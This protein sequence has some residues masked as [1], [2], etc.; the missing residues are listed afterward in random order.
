[1]KKLKILTKPTPISSS[2][3]EDL[4]D[5]ETAWIVKAER[6]QARRWHKLRERTA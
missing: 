2:N 5:E 6:L 1:M 4:F 3:L